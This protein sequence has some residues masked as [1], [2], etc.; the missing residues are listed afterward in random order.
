MSVLATTGIALMSLT[1]ARPAAADPTAVAYLKPYVTW[2]E[3]KPNGTGTYALKVVMVSMDNGGFASYAENDLLPF[4]D[5]WG[6]VSF[7][8]AS[9]GTAGTQYFNNRRYKLPGSGLFAPSYPF[10]PTDTDVLGISLDANHGTLTLT[11]SSWGGYQE[12]ADLHAA[13]GVLTGVVD[14]TG[15]FPTTVV[16]RVSE[17]FIPPPPPIK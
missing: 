2:A 9:G 15:Y 7:N 1:T 11:F 3:T 17:S 8:S 10:S 4:E 6:W 12:I 5:V 16:L 13:H 14:P